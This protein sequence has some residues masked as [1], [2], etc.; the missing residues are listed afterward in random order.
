M[1]SPHR[2]LNAAI[3]PLNLTK[4]AAGMTPTK[5]AFESTSDLL[6]VGLGWVSF[7]STS[8]GGWLS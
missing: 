7:R 2:I 4:E 6:T 8:V 3:N 1:L 5:A